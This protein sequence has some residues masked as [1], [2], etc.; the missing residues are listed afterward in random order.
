MGQVI[1]GFYRN[2]VVYLVVVAAVGA[3]CIYIGQTTI[4]AF[5][6]MLLGLMIVLWDA[7]TD[8]SIPPAPSIT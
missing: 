7:H 3:L 5:L 4:A 1:D 2:A 8:P 6:F